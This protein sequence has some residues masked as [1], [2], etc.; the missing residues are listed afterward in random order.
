[1]LQ[2]KWFQHKDGG[3]VVG[4]V[5]EARSIDMKASEEA[6]K[7]MWKMVPVMYH[8]VAGHHDVSHTPIKPHNK[9]N[10]C[11]QFPGAWEFYQAQRAEAAPKDAGL[12]S[13][14]TVIKGTL[15]DKA[16]FI[17]RTQMAFL[18]TMG[19][20]TIEQLAGMSDTVAQ[21]LKGGVQMRKKAQEFLKRT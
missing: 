4:Y 12:V 18:V 14:E 7:T 17:P 13:P 16:D 6:G 11:N 15:L 20:S 3:N 1:M 5:G 21:G 8:K 19:F 10:I 9:D 2:E